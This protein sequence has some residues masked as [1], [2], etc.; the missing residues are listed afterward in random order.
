MSS[1]EMSRLDGDI[2]RGVGGDRVA[3]LRV[4]NHCRYHVGHC[5]DIPHSDAIARP[6]SDLLAIGNLLAVAEVDEIVLVP[7]GN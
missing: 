1:I 3:W 6:G 5:G 7:S 2:E 4:G